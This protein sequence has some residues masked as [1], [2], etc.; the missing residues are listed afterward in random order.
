M[1]YSGTGGAFDVL[2]N[3]AIRNTNMSL[4]NFVAATEVGCFN[5]SVFVVIYKGTLPG[6]LPGMLMIHQEHA[7]E[8]RHSIPIIN[9]RRTCAGRVTEVV[10]CVCL[11]VCLRLF[12]HYRLRGGL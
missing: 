12:S 8:C 5:P 1:E 9:P 3:Q 7:W 2:R 6:E 10:V 4:A 11:S